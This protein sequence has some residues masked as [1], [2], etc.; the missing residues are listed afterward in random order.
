MAKDKRAKEDDD[1]YEYVYEYYT[2]RNYL[3][4]FLAFAIPMFILCLIAGGII[5]DFYSNK[6]P[7]PFIINFPEKPKKEQLGSRN[8]FNY[9]HISEEDGVTYSIFQRELP[10][11]YLSL[12][13]S[14]KKKKEIIDE[15]TKKKLLEM[16]H[17]DN[18]NASTIYKDYLQRDNYICQELKIK[19]ND[20]MWCRVYYWRGD[21]IIVSVTASAEIKVSNNPKVAE[22]FNSLQLK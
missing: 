1:G 12:F 18:S 7:V 8:D 15:M 9:Q 2:P 13:H 19:S 11:P 3:S 6:P 16:A 20:Y 17:L 10:Y 21:Y 22:F 14:Q 4:I 5:A